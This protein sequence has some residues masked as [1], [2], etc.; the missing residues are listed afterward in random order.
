MKITNKIPRYDLFLIC[1]GITL[2][3]GVC[4]YLLNWNLSSILAPF[5]TV[6]LLLLCK[7]ALQELNKK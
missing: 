6:L 3:L 2:I 5:N 4:G 1:I 7:P